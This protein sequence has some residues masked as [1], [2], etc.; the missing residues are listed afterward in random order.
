M[1]SPKERRPEQQHESPIKRLKFEVSFYFQL[2]S[3]LTFLI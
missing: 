2:T 1:E 3:I